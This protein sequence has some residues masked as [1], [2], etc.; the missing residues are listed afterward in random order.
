[1]TDQK[2]AAIYARTATI[3][4]NGTNNALTMQV[5]ECTQYAV[6]KG[7]IVPQDQIYQEVISGNAIKRPILDGRLARNLQTLL[8]HLR[9]FKESGVLVETVI[10]M[11]VETAAGHI[12]TY[13]NE[14]KKQEM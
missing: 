1:M 5:R 9:V 6:S 12:T 2:K 4:E 14:F 8:E 13:M 3:Q 7:Y 11:S 10:K